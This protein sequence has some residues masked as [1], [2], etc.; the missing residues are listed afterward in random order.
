MR[1]L[2]VLLLVP[3]VILAFAGM[4]AGDAQYPPALGYGYDCT[5]WEQYSDPWSSGEIIY[6]PLGAGGGA[7]WLVCPGCTEYVTWPPLDIELW[8][9]MECVLTW[10]ET[11][12][13]IHRASDYEDFYLYFDGT[14]ACNNGQYIITTPPSGGSLDVLPFVEDIFGRTTGYGTDIP[15]TWEVSVD[16]GAWTALTDDE[17]DKYFLVDACDHSFRIRVLVDM[18]YH[19]EDGYYHL[20]GEGCTICPASPL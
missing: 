17:G 8:I 14:S 19:Q 3:A 1:N 12:V 5:N 11:Q 18:A 6:D 4:V 15:L 16:G 9:E 2:V 13:D 20:G 10:D 7:A